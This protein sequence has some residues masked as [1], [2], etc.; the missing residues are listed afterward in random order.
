MYGR[1]CS[2][3]STRFSRKLDDKVWSKILFSTRSSVIA[4]AVEGLSSIAIGTPESS[5]SLSAPL[6]LTCLSNSLSVA[7]SFML[8]ESIPIG[9]QLA[10]D[11][12]EM[13]FSSSAS[14][15]R[16]WL[17]FGAASTSSSSLGNGVRGEVTWVVSKGV[18]YTSR[19]L[20]D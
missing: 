11:L 17:R 14:A 20:C 4:A 6:A 9:G 1:A 10:M 12:K 19:S 13:S 5:T 15:S 8:M 16:S 3:L 7:G 18:L 2:L